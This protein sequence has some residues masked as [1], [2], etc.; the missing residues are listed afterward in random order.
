MSFG[1]SSY[2]RTSYASKSERHIPVTKHR[3]NSEYHRNVTS[4][5]QSLTP[6]PPK[7]VEVGEIAERLERE[8]EQEKASLEASVKVNSREK[9]LEDANAEKERQISA[10][11]ET[12]ANKHA[13]EAA[14]YNSIR[15]LKQVVLQQQLLED[16][17]YKSHA[18]CGNKLFEVDAEAQSFASS[19]VA[20]G[21]GGDIQVQQVLQHIE[22][23]AAMQRSHR[24]RLQE[25]LARLSERHTQMQAHLQNFTDLLE[26][27]GERQMAQHE[28]TTLMS[29]KY[30]VMEKQHQQTMV[31][32]GEQM[33]ASEQESRRQAEANE[34]QSQQLQLLMEAT[35]R[36]QDQLQRF[37]ET[38]EQ[39]QDQLR[40]ISQD[41]G[42]QRE[43]QQLLRLEWQQQLRDMNEAFLKQETAQ[44]EQK[45]ILLETTGK[46][47][48]LERTLQDMS[49]GKVQE[50]QELRRAVDS[51]Q[52]QLRRI[53]QDSGEQREQQQQLLRLEWQ[54]QLRDMNEAF[55]KQEAAQR[56]Q[57]DILLETNG[58]CENLE[59]TLQ[60]VSEGKVQETQ[61]LRRAVEYLESGGGI[62]KEY[63]EC[64]Q[65][66]RELSSTWANQLKAQRKQ[67]TELVRVK[68]VK[69]RRVMKQEKR[70]VLSMLNKLKEQFYYIAAEQDA[71]HAQS[72]QQEVQA[73][74]QAVQ[75]AMQQASHLGCTTVLVEDG[76]S[77]PCSK[78]QTA[79]NL[80][81]QDVQTA[82]QPAVQQDVQTA[83]QP[84]V[85]Q[86][87]QQARQIVPRLDL[88]GMERQTPPAAPQ[89]PE[90]RALQPLP[91]LTLECAPR[92]REGGP[93]HGSQS[94]QQST[95]S[96][97]PPSSVC[98][99]PDQEGAPYHTPQPTPQST[100]ACT[101]RDREL[102]P[103]RT[104]TPQSTPA[105]TPR[106]RELIPDRAPTAQVTP[107]CIPHDSYTAPTPYHPGNLLMSVM[108]KM[109][110]HLWD[111]TAQTEEQAEQD[112]QQSI[113]QTSQPNMQQE[114]QQASQLDARQAVDEPN[115]AAQAMPHSSP[116][117]TARDRDSEQDHT[118]QATPQ[119]TPACT[120]RL[121]ENGPVHTPDSTPR[122]ASAYPHPRVSQLSRNRYHPDDDPDPGFILSESQVRQLAELDPQ[123]I[124]HW[125]QQVAKDGAVPFLAE[126]FR[127]V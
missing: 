46:C 24:L 82:S 34:T 99:P 6:L 117:L 61:E 100:P 23:T 114:V 102:I 49:E 67:Q 81:Q 65:Q 85:Q 11:T 50:T 13:Q 74:Q 38:T 21:D 101:P 75:E 17:H 29:V 18:I 86:D 105:C 125:V 124:L 96:R 36:Q 109:Q 112:R 80:P 72:V 76:L 25:E 110:E 59:R 103:D 108:K 27:Q 126:G 53:S 111:T 43:Q 22:H 93:D 35:A 20:N 107:P 92:D 54:Q 3:R 26:Q 57:K 4:E 71:H 91:Q 64:F 1:P 31:W 41:S 70:K 7:G 19:S 16:D 2:R 98:T 9:E 48:N 113:S 52:Y 12:L 115:H 60:D 121:W 73:A 88:R 14:N 118:P 122:S 66:V 90:C 39:H 47:E 97:T 10:L 79:H 68:H 127:K 44:R 84:A 116:T 95:H 32:L 15:D 69:L 94:P 51:L 77:L 83:S 120:P 104:P 40:R 8:R 123:R 37:V 89:S 119:S 30:E 58:K 33:D 63:Q 78:M 55:L 62:R 45:D 42:E 106:D 28:E 5:V 56:E 87:A